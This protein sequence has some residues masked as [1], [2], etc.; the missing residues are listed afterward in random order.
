MEPMMCRASTAASVRGSFEFMVR[1]LVIVAE[2]E[3]A[4]S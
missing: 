2:F 1:F 4:S 3:G